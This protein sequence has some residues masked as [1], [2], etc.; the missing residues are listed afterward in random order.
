M[1][2]ITYPWNPYQTVDECNITTPEVITVPGGDKFDI[3]PR[4]A[5]FHKKGLVIEDED[6]GAILV[7]GVDF[8]FILPF[9]LL[10]AE[11]NV[12]VVGGVALLK[13]VVNKRYIVKQYSTVGQPFVLSD[14]AYA[15]LVGN[16]THST[17][18]GT[19]DQ[20]VN[21]PPEGLPGDPHPHP[22]SKLENF[23]DL[24]EQLK[25]MN[26]FL[27][28]ELNNPT[29]LTKLIEHMETAFRLA[30]PNA[31]KADLG[32]DLLHNYDVV[33]EE[34]LKGNSNEL[35]MT[36]AMCRLLFEKLL[37][38]LGLYP[39]QDP[40]NPG[41]GEEGEQPD[42]NKHLTLGEAINLFLSQDALLAEIRLRGPDAQAA[43]RDNLGLGTAA[44]ADVLQGLGGSETDTMSQKAIT[45]LIA[46]FNY[47]THSWLYLAEG[48]ELTLEPPF[49]FLNC[50]LFIQGLGQPTSY[51]FTIVDS[52]VMLAEPL[53]KGDLVELVSD[54]P[55]VKSWFYT[56]TGG[57]LELDPPYRL[58]NAMVYLEGFEQPLG[59]S[60]TFDEHKVYLASPLVAGERVE[61]V[62]D[63]PLTSQHALYVNEQVAKLSDDLDELRL[64]L[65]QLRGI[66]FLSTDA[67]N[68]VHVGSDRNIYMSPEDLQY[69]TGA[70]V[71]VTEINKSEG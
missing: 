62:F 52:I 68:V 4:F 17:R 58:N 28:N 57:E 66:D 27:G 22:A 25:L 5:P 47:E 21:L 7:P 35:Y 53:R 26:D 51:S 69:I 63:A 12:D 37:K 15:E 41:D 55:I 6:T 40:T 64:Q 67:N 42:H 30:H 60:F 31:N 54:A 18:K 10:N 20:V 13:D 61:V 59:Y 8:E 44:T 33:K 65:E 34:D 43:A 39:S 46:N 16:I 70:E 14:L 24:I 9:E 11:K 56:A 48:G 45:E 3:I 71:E 38:E 19:W 29:V 36:L 32:L 49:Q 2:N 1:N 23:N 50:L